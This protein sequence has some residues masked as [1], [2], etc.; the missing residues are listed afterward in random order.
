MKHKRILIIPL[1][2]L[3]IFACTDQNQSAG[4]DQGLP[5]ETGDEVLTEALQQK[6][7]SVTV[8]IGQDQEF[9][10]QVRNENE[11]KKL[12]EEDRQALIDL[13]I[14]D[15]AQKIEEKSS[16]IVGEKEQA[17]SGNVNKY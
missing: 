3:C 10:R 4:S 15:G 9:E 7:M 12:S 1:L 14:Q 11:L 13:T 17:V 5:E 8:Q 6:L 16:R 2:L